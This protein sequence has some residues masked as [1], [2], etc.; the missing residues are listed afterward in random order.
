MDDSVLCKKLCNYENVKNLEGKIFH[1]KWLICGSRNIDPYHRT[2]M[3]LILKTVAV[4][5]VKW[6]TNMPLIIICNNLYNFTV[7][8]LDRKWIQKIVY[9]LMT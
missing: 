7:I 1:K 8:F 9:F 4:Q 5:M 2:Q 3:T 6:K